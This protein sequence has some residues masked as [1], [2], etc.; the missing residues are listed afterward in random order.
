MTKP[1][2]TPFDQLGMNDVATV[3]DSALT[4][5]ERERR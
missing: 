3:G 2:T 5:S 4:T 1:L